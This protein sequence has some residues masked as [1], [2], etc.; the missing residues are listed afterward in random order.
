[1]KDAGKKNGDRSQLI[2]DELKSVVGGLFPAGAGRPP[3]KQ[4]QAHSTVTSHPLVNHPV[5]AGGGAGG[6][7]QTSCPPPAATG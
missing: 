5:A 3:T 7:C 1:M 6:V 2:D 4:P